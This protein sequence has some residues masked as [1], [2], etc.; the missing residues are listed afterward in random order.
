MLKYLALIISVLVFLTSISFASTGSAYIYASAVSSLGVGNLTVIHLNVTAGNGNVMIVGPQSVANDTFNSAVSAVNE[1]TAYLN[2]NKNNYNF[3]YTINYSSVSGPS[4]GLAMTLLAISVLSNTP[5]MHNFAVTGTISSSGSVGEIGGVYEKSKVAFQAGKQFMIVPF[6]GNGTF[7]NSLYYIVQQKLGIPVIKVS[8]VSQALPYAFGLVAPRRFAYNITQ[9]YH[10]SQIPQLNISCT[11]CNTSNF[12]ILANATVNLTRNQISQIHGNYSLLK[13]S[14]RNSLS[15]FTQIINKG[16]LYTGADLSFLEFSNA[17]LFANSNFTRIAG[18]EIIANVSSYCG[19]LSPPQLTTGN[20]EYVIG[21]ELRQSWALQTLN[22]SANELANAE[23][24][25]DVAQSIYGAANAYA[26]CFAASQM[27]KIGASYSSGSVILSNEA[28][29]G[30]HQNV[31]AVQN[32]SGLYSSAALTSYNQG[33]YGAALYNAKYAMIFGNSSYVFYPQSK[34]ANLTYANIANASGEGIW[35]Y[36]FSAHALFYLNQRSFAQSNSSALSE[37][38]NAY[39]LSALALS[40]SDANMFLVNGFVPLQV[41]PGTSSGTDIATLQQNITQIYQVL[42]ILA[43]LVFV[44]FLIIIYLI[45]RQTPSSF[46]VTAKA[47]RQSR[48]ARTARRR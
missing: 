42:F 35:P 41:V 19:S 12:A 10:T 20:Y 6:A 5:L 18:D 3:K 28:I 44:S 22:N 1:A 48:R 26:W 8:N 36:E 47:K 13:Q 43:A 15:N 37:A 40:L 11:E 31:T 30:I 39:S 34:L 4:G 9:N 17:Y 38:Q 2:Q 45:L 7:E 24:T 27:Y 14:L 23:I 32:S 29:N 33:L 21:G 16:Y 46:T 25:D